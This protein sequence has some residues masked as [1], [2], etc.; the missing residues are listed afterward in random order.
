[1]GHIVRNK[2]AAWLALLLV[3]APLACGAEAQQST[4][5]PVPNDDR[6]RVL[7]LRDGGML[8]GHIE[9]D[10]DLFIVSRSGSQLRV[11]ADRVLFEGASL[12]EAYLER[13]RQIAYPTADAHLALAEWCLRYDLVARA[14]QEVARARAIDAAHPRLSLVERRLTYAE[15]TRV[16]T[17][18]AVAEG[19]RRRAKPAGLPSPKPVV[20]PNLGDVPVTVVERFTRKVQPVLVNNCTAS[21]CHRLD[22]AEPFQLDRALLHGL[23]NRRSTMSNLAAALALVDRERPQLSPLLTVPRRAHG[24]LTKPVF[25]PRQEQAFQH[26]VEWVALV[27]E[28]HA[29][30]SETSPTG[31]E[32]IGD[33]VLAGLSDAA[34]DLR[35]SPGAAANDVVLA[36]GDAEGAAD[37]PK[38][39]KFGAR[40]EPWKPRDPFDPE[41][42]NRRQ[43]APK[44]APSP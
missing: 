32:P 15:H 16:H 28:P 29:P 5:Q 11:A 9:R 40:V 14:R 6:Q 20:G 44:G 37:S 39:P 21:G 33:E 25:G 24:G 18:T 19:M 8:T 17:R 23:T 27:S 30:I 7:V 43:R 3:V 41:I 38:P 34:G 4:D 36:A 35:L 22:G 2:M 31:A 13:R 1:M 26:L 42:F 12:D 10:G